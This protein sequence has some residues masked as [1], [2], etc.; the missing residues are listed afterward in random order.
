MFGEKTVLQLFSKRIFC[1]FFWK[2]RTEDVQRLC[3]RGQQDLILVFW[4]EK[5]KLPTPGPV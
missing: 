5:W 4:L 2:K 1:G 3:R